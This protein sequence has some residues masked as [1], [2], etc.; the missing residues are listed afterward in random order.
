MYL[1]VLDNGHT[2][3]FC[4]VAAVSLHERL[5][6]AVVYLNYDREDTRD[7]VLNEVNIPLFESL[8]HNSVVGISEGL[9]NDVPSL[10]PAVAAVI[11]EN[12]HELGD[13]ESRVMWIA[14]FSARFSRV[15]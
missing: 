5:A 10:V 15:P 13:S 11:E 12:T 14:T 4:A 3:S 9:R 1:I 6:V 2:C 7:N 8:S